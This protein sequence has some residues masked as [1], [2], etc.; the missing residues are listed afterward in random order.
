[1]W[2]VAA[3]DGAKHVL[4]DAAKISELLPPDTEPASQA[5]GLGRV[6][7][8]KYYWSADSSEMVFRSGGKLTWLDLRTMQTKV[9]AGGK[10]GGSERQPRR[11][12]RSEIF[13]RRQICH[14]P[15]RL[16]ISG[17]RTS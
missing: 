12:R 8:H 1:L 11:Y 2:S 4:V 13:A 3:S 14:L 15:A 9:L 10:S 7:A 17:S 5:T 16:G 6:A